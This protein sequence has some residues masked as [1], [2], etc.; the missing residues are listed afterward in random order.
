MT[1]NGGSCALMFEKPLKDY[2]GNT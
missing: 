2:D 1:D